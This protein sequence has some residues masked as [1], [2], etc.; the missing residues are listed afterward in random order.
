[1]IV[2]KIYYDT[3]CLCTRGVVCKSSRRGR[4]E[5]E[6]GGQRVKI[7]SYCFGYDWFIKA[8]CNKIA[9]FPSFSHKIFSASAALDENIR[10]RKQYFINAPLMYSNL[11][12]LASKYFSLNKTLERLKRKFMCKLKSSQALC[13]SFF[14]VETWKIS[15]RCKNAK[16]L[17]LPL[18]LGQ[19]LLVKWNVALWMMGA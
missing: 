16:A 15:K 3:L 19:K 5:G 18:C 6:E 7:F 14:L 2:N 11:F 13:S 12:L 17:K 1:M 4:G 8:F 9:F 10:L